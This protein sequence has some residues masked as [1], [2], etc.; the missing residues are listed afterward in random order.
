VKCQ[1]GRNTQQMTQYNAGNPKVAEQ[2]NG[3]LPV[4]IHPVTAAAAVV[5]VARQQFIKLTCY[6]TVFLK[7]VC[8][9]EYFA[10]APTV[11]IKKQRIVYQ[12]MQERELL[13]QG[14][15]DVFLRVAEYLLSKMADMEANDR[16]DLTDTMV[17][18]ML[19]E[20]TND[21]LTET[22]FTELFRRT[23]ALCASHGIHI[24]TEFT[25]QEGT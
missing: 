2:H 7:A 17:D 4:L 5:A 25:A 20:F 14:E 11:F 13:L 10:L 18:R 8:T 24:S 16:R 22:E 19:W 3:I 6:I 12:L 9:L 1:H 21:Q 15:S 23:D